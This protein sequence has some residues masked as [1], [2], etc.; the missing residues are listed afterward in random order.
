VDNTASRRSLESKKDGE[1]KL[2]DGLQ[3]CLGQ[4]QKNSKI[5]RGSLVASAYFD[6]FG[7]SV[8]TPEQHFPQQAPQAQAI[9]HLLIVLATRYRPYGWRLH[10]IQPCDSAP[11]RMAASRSRATRA[12]AACGS[13]EVPSRRRADGSTRPA[14]GR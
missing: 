3:E 13:H 12:V 2:A 7:F 11:W 14:A 10:N 1:L 9:T 8:L 4:P 5:C 6:G